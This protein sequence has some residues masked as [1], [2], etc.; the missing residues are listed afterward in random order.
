[1]YIYIYIY[2]QRERER[3]RDIGIDINTDILL[4]SI[5]VFSDTYHGIIRTAFYLR[6]PM[7]LFPLSENLRLC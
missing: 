6:L 3:E 7:I 1:M 5:G 4:Y 2:I